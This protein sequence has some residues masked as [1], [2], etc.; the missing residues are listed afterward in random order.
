MAT[1]LKPTALEKLARKPRRASQPIGTIAFYG[2]DDKRASKMV[3]TVMNPGDEQPAAIERWFTEG[4]ARGDHR[5]ARAAVEFLTRNGVHQ[6]AMAGRIIGCPHEEG[7]DY[8]DGESC[9]QCPFWIG[10]DRFTG[11]MIETTKAPSAERADALAQLGR[12]IRQRRDR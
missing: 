11:E 3:V 6:V 10:R 5:L 7:I 4:D 2:P 1:R 12:Q 8:P 9:P